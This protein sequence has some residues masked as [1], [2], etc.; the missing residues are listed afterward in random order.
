VGGASSPGVGM[1]ELVEDGDD[2]LMLEEN[3]DDE[4]L[5]LEDNDDELALEDNDDDEL[6]LE[7]NDD[8][9]I[10]L[11][12]NTA[13][14]DDDDDLLL[15]DNGED[16]VP[17]DEEE[18]LLE[19]NDDELVMEANDA[20]ATEG[21]IEALRAEGRAHYS[22]KQWEAARCAYTSALSCRG[23][24]D[25]AMRALLLANRAQVFVK[26]SNWASVINDCTAALTL[27]DIA[28]ETRTKALF[29]RATAFVEVGD[30]QSA[31]RDITSLLPSSDPAVAKLQES[32]A[33]LQASAVTRPLSGA[34]ALVSADPK[35]RRRVS[36]IAPTT[37]ERH[38]FHETALYR[39]F[40]AQTHADLE[41]VVVD[42]GP[43][44][45]PF[46]T[47]PSFSDPRVKYIHQFENMTIGEKRNLA[48]AQASGDVICHFDDD[49]LYA[50]EYVATLL[51]EMDRHNA[52]FVKLSAWFVHDLQTGR[53]GIFDAE[54]GMPHPSLQQLRE[55]FLYTY[56]FSFMYARNLFP[57]FSFMATS[58]GEDQDILKKVRE[59]GKALAL[60]ND[61]R[62]ICLHNQ[63]G[64]NCSRSF[65]QRTL[66]QAELGA[67][68]LGPLLDALPTIASA[69]CSRKVEAEDGVYEDQTVKSDVAG[70]LFCWDSQLRACH[71]DPDAT[72]QAFTAW[73]WSGNGF[74]KDRYTKLNLERPAP[75][76]KL[77]QP[78]Q[79][80]L[81]D[82][83]PNSI[84]N[85]V[86]YGLESLRANEGLVEPHAAG[87]ITNPVSYQPGGIGNPD[88]PSSKALDRLGLGSATAPK[89][90]FAF[91]S[92]ARTFVP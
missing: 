77:G 39:C 76:T 16:A 83:S 40:A 14:D 24:V 62:G 7:D 88:R 36:C 3:D 29:R 85:A 59:A 31:T 34:H 42:T 53:T 75:P 58:W 32:L 11:E 55:Q 1:P 27:T 69:L 12:D 92:T 9:D 43:R 68:P 79:P 20:T 70:G 25:N 23:V 28:P 22:A 37:P 65:A 5:A 30:D 74:S 46:F 26:E 48:I 19:D 73:L 61:R 15:E 6:A 90:T 87:A 78:K 67:T 63:H 35:S 91:G 45:S 81:T 33:K 71:G 86:G 44:P 82:S 72:L 84:G 38:L 2:E 66:S 13:E 8:G 64:E 80:Q 52:D 57:T 4:E 50:P 41:L 54:A 21:D 56:G 10:L 51:A 17:E 60:Y 89:P 47:S 49:D 18:L